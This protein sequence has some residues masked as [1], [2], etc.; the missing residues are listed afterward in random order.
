MP[1]ERIQPE[2]L[3]HPPTYSHVVKAGDTVYIAGQTPRDE[4]GNV[5]APSDFS[6]QATQ[7]F[8]NLAKALAAA[9]AEFGDLVK[10]TVYLTDRRYREALG[11][12]SGRYIT[13]PLPA[14]TVVIVAG[15]FHPDYLLEIEA[16]AVLG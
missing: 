4:Q 7:V 1:K 13:G 3:F 8:E 2:G 9:G 10:M 6:A 14:S 16:I 11:E 5:L 15:L 12:V